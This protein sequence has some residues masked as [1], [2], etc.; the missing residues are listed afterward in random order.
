MSIKVANNTRANVQHI[1][2]D[3][4]IFYNKKGI[5]MPILA[6]PRDKAALEGE[7]TC[8]DGQR[9]RHCRVRDRHPRRYGG[10]SLLSHCQRDHRKKEQGTVSDGACEGGDFKD[11]N[12]KGTHPMLP[13]PIVAAI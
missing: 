2:D 12:S 4:D 7:L 8:R 9:C 3:Y 13:F 10:L 6:N 1:A 11:E 5:A